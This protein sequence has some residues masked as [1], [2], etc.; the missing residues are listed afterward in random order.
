MILAPELLRAPPTPHQNEQ[1]RGRAGRW[2][3]ILLRS[4][5]RSADF[6]ACAL[7]TTAPVVV[8]EAIAV[9]GAAED[10]VP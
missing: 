8:W 5:M 4:L 10:E 3:Q 6:W 1:D 7:A 2:L 9:R